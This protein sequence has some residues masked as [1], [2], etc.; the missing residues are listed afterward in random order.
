MKYTLL[1]LAYMPLFS[2]VNYPKDYFRQPMDIPMQLSGNFGELR[3]NH[4]HAGFDFKTQQKEG[5]IVHAS[6]DGYISRIRISPY[7]YGKAIYIDHP[8]G[9]TTVYGHLQKGYKGVEDFIQK[10]QY[11]EQSYE[12]DYLPKPGE[13]PIKKGDTIAYSGNTGGSEGPH[14]HF[15]F[16]D[17]KSE[18]VINPLLFGLEIKDTKRPIVTSL[19]AYPIG[20]S[21]VVNQSSRP[22]MINLSLQ[23]DGSFIAEKVLASGQLGFGITANDFDDV[24]YNNNGIYKAE[25]F[26]NG[27]SNFSYQFDTF[28][29]DEGRYVNALIDYPRYKKTKVRVQQLFM[30]QSFPLSII[31]ASAGNGLIQMAPNV[32][33]SYRIEVSDFSGNKTTIIIPIE[34]AV[35]PAK[36]PSETVK[37]PYFVKA[38]TDSSFEKG[39]MSVFLPAGTFYNDFYLNFDVIDSVMTVQD[40]YTAVHSNFQVAIK[41]HSVAN[42]EKTFIASVS[43]K[44]LSYNPTKFKDNVFTAYTKNLGQFKLAKDTIAPRITIAKPIEGKWITNQKNIQLSISDNLSGIKSYSGFINEKWVLFEYDYKSKKITYLIDDGQLAEGKNDLKV[45]VS[46][47]LGN[48]AIFETQFFRSQKQ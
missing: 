26:Y 44:N 18:K 5:Q 37:T 3:P 28:A 35:S 47:N 19:V 25:T 29:F 2:Q 12:I 34:Y 7:G 15:E 31:H 43:G 27:Q 21:S 46:D 40:D 36:V 48:S 4:F 9:Y 8:N 20:D 30:R 14:L 17:T 41:S 24:S 6:A 23:P 1:L 16:R 39:D 13:F 42:T 38:K 32:M 22:I 33:L 45:I 10:E 11:K